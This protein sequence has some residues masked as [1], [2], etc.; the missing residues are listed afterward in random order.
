MICVAQKNEK[1][2]A[3]AQAGFTLMEILIAVV[4][5]GLIMAAATVGYQKVLEGQRKS[6]TG[7]TLKTVQSAI[8]MFEMQMNGLPETLDDLIRKPE[9]SERFDQDA[10]SNWQDGGYLDKNKYPV[11]AWGKKLQYEL[12][13]EEGAA[14]PYE[15]WSYGSRDGNRAPKDKRI[16]VWNK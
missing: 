5:V 6:I 4:I 15:L 7:Q 8:T 9:P 14:H 2:R 1:V 16:S 10:L 11:D 3:Q 12:T 13:Q